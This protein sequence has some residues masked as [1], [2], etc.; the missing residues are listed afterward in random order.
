MDQ[1]IKNSFLKKEIQPY[2]E[3]DSVILFHANNLDIVSSLTSISCISSDPPYS[4][5]MKGMKWDYGLP[6]K[7]LWKL[8]LNTVRLGGYATIFGGTKTSHRMFC[9]VEDAG[10]EIRDTLM[11]LYSGMPKGTKLSTEIE[12]AG[13]NNEDYPNL[14]GYGTGLRPCYEPILLARKPMESTLL[15]C[16]LANGTGALNLEGSKILPFPSA[17]FG[18]TPCNLTFDNSEEVLSELAKFGE[19]SSRPHGFH[20]RENGVLY[21]GNTLTE[22]ATKHHG[23]VEYGDSGSVA[24]FYKPCELDQEDI[25]NSRIFYSTKACKSEKGKFNTH[26]SVK[27]KNLMKYLIK[28]TCPENGIILDPFAGSG[29]TGVA[30]KELGF[31]CIL[32]EQEEE[33]CEIAA[34]RLQLVK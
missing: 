2:Y 7:E 27:P 29:T 8:C 15:D 12:S 9:T 11:W 10:W 1:L 30:A 20:E 16:V 24:R 33:Y 4:L 34:K 32:I 14:Q 3:D 22:S 23:T 18:R 28:L 26:I 31:K 21:G 25:E 6:S 13:L 19:S 17:T 5:K